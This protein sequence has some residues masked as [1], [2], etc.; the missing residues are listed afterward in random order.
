MAWFS[1]EEG[2]DVLSVLVKA[3]IEGITLLTRGAL[4]EQYGSYT[5][6]VGAD[7]SVSVDLSHSS[8]T[9]PE[10]QTRNCSSFFL[11]RPPSPK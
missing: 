3:K 10:E 6:G 7:R 11:E 1:V 2:G 4:H 9:Q 8:V 5:F